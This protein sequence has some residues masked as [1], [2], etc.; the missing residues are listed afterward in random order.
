MDRCGEN[1]WGNLSQFSK[2]YLISEMAETHSDSG[3]IIP[4]PGVE[5]RQCAGFL[6]F[7]W[8]QSVWIEAI[9]SGRTTVR[10]NITIDEYLRDQFFIQLGYMCG[11]KVIFK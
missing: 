4:V 1:F 11:Y 6:H 3:H 9:D 8:R 10:E 7:D 5:A 2:I